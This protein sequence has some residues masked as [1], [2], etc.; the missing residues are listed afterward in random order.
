[1]LSLGALGR[2]HA[3]VRSPRRYDVTMST[4][5]VERYPYGSRRASFQRVILLLF[6][7]CIHRID[8]GGAI[9]GDQAGEQRGHD[10][11]NR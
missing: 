6:V 3:Q 1:M 4:T 7:Q 8:S 11:E 5:L 2:R 10:K 9:G